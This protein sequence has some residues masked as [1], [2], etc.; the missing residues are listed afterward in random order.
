MSSSSFGQ[1]PPSSPFITTTADGILTNERILTAG[2]GI[3]II[4]DG[5][6]ISV[7][8]IGGAGEVVPQ[9]MTTAEINAL[10]NPASGLVVKDTDTKQILSNAGTPSVPNWV[11][12][13]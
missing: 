3:S 11:I 4:D 12:L 5:T 6:N 7:T 10:I 1:S 2:A 8:N 9:N 13:G